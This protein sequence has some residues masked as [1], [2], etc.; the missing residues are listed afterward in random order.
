MSKKKM[1]ETEP[2]TSIGDQIPQPNE[3]DTSMYADEENEGGSLG[4]LDFNVEDEFKPDPLIPKGTYH[5][6]ATEIRFEPAKFCIVWDFCLHDNGG[7]MSDGET[8]ID[9]AHVTYR[10]WLPKPGDEN[11]MSKSGKSTKRQS[12]INMLKDFQDN[13]GLDMSTPTI[14][15]T[16]LSEQLWVGTE[17]DLDV[18]V[19]EWQG[20]FRNTVNRAN[21]SKMF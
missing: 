20:R 8:P 3:L 19:D 18:D 10:N 15:A 9:G 5:A 6:V 14:I 12:K 17:A 1:T 11:E 7:M 4:D 13:L 16:S 21:Q 2:E